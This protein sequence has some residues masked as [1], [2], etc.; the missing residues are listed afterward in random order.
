MSFKKIGGDS[1]LQQE[2]SSLKENFEQQTV[3]TTE[4]ESVEDA[5]V[6]D[7][8]SQAGENKQ[9]VGGSVVE[10]QSVDYSKYISP[11]EFEERLNERMSSHDPLQ[12]VSDRIKKMIE[13]EQ[14]GGVIDDVFL[15]YQSKDFST[16]NLEDTNQAL[17]IL[18]ESY[19]LENPDLSSS[20][21]DH[22]FKMKYPNLHS[23]NVDLEDSDELEVYNN[24]K[25]SLS[26]DA[27]Q[28]LKTL[29]EYKEKV[30]LPPQSSPQ[31][32]QSEEDLKKYRKDAENHLK[33]FGGISMNFGEGNDFTFEA[34]PENSKNSIQNVMNAGETFF[35]RYLNP[36][37]GIDFEKF[38]LEMF[39]LDNWEEMAKSIWELS[40][41]SREEKVISETLTN[42]N[43]DPR[44][45][46]TST[47]KTSR[48]RMIE[49]FNSG[50]KRKFD[51]L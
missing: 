41:S 9:H 13:F 17:S 4:T 37:G 47:G 2:T 14:Q 51:N 3:E 12:G 7:N 32:K 10:S 31:Q 42:Q 19:S 33:D 15:K 11:E 34:T 39:L 8:S 36:G 49:S 23:K 26:I 6:D 1:D 25:M 43:L 5:V 44:R 28:A 27:T 30:M 50:M 24:E 16:V 48:E 38:N 45:S 21:V 18:K 29:K 20:Q 22:I 35:D 40:A 46:E